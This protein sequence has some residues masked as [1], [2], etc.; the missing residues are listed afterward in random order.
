MKRMATLMVILLL[1]GA[2]LYAATPMM[3]QTGGPGRGYT[4]QAGTTTGG[5]YQL[6]SLTWHVHRTLRVS[7][8]AGG[9]AYSLVVA[10][11][12]ALGGNQCCCTFLPIVLRNVQ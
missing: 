12:S 7:G 6:T 4:V 3:A 9:R 11:R 2:T 1:G 10:D 5:G 8:A